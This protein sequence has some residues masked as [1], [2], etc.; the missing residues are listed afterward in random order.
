MSDNNGVV[1]DTSLRLSQIRDK[2]S[3]SIISSIL[4]IQKH[5]FTRDK[6][7]L[8][9]LECLYREEAIEE[10]SSK[11]RRV[12]NGSVSSGA[13]QVLKRRDLDPVLGGSSG[14]DYVAV[15]YTWEPSEEEED[16]EPEDETVKRYLVEPREAGRPAVLSEVR[17]AVWR[18]TLSYAD[19]VGCK[20]IWIDRECID[21]DE[22]GEKESAIQNMHLV[23][24]LSEFPVALLTYSIDT[25]EELD[26]LVSFMS[27]EVS[28]EDEP[29]VLDLLNN[30]T[31]GLWW[32]R[33]W[34]YQEDYKASI[35]MKLLL[36][37]HPSLE[38]R[39][40]DAQDSQGDGIFPEL[41]GEICINSAIFR[42]L[43]TEFCV[44]YRKKAEK[45]DIC[46]KILRA[47]PKYNVYLRDERCV[48][49][50]SRA[51]SPQIISDI[52]SRDITL[53]SDRLAIMANCCTYDTRLNTHALNKSGSSLSLSIL[54]LY[55]LNG[56]LMENHPSRPL[57]GTLEDNVH[58]YISR[59][60]LDSFRP[61]TPNALT[62][63]KGCRFINPKFSIDG[64]QTRGYIWELG[65]IIRRKP[66]KLQKYRTLPEL[67]EFATELSFQRF[68]DSCTDLIHDLL[69]WVRRRD[70]SWEWLELMT[71][72]VED[73]LREGKS[74]RLGKL[75][76]PYRCKSGDDQYKAIFVGDSNNDWKDESISYAF[77][78]VWPGSDD[79]PEDMHK[80][81]SL[82]VD[83]K[84]PKQEDFEG[85]SSSLPK[86]YIKRWL[87][88]L[89]LF[90]RCPLQSVLFPWHPALL[91]EPP[92]QDD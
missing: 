71:A 32:T 63:I 55:L 27:E 47:A 33:A 51:M 35:R 66:M 50:A 28:V 39:K 37:H 53:E 92:E 57:R 82:E 2:T 4:D 90:K 26:L 31:S 79:K 85:R 12:A 84:W 34:T 81:V 38:E 78:S 10:P 62:F 88:G 91:E 16:Q 23:Y 87:N 7:W 59:Q 6:N 72:E 18:R 46:D 17:N 13:S 1:K 80:H 30:I 25:E 20:N 54:A 8:R 11:R 45:R 64:T 52:V 42:E 3:S 43:A 9:S 68:S 61:P 56:E 67:D 29:A 89:C 76:E 49:S 21:Q 58:K 15:S 24:S 73:A 14:R 41:T 75:A 74:L 65:P 83:V 86:L 5:T 60:S 44:A 40:R 19:Y 48:R 70:H 77:T 36:P 22:S 69:G